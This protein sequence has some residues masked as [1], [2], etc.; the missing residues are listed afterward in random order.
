MKYSIIIPHHNV[1]GLLKRCL[2]S[3]PQR[4]DLEVIVVDDKSDD[5][6]ITE[7][8]SICDSRQNTQLLLLSENRGG[9]GARNEGLK[10]AQGDFLLF[11]DAD[12]FFNYCINDILDEYKNTTNDLVFF[13]ANCVDSETYCIDSRTQHLNAY[14]DQWMSN[15]KES[16]INLR[17]MFGEPWCKLIRKS[18]VISHDIKFDT[19]RRNN[20][21]TFSYLVGYFS[22]NISVDQR[23]LYCYTTGRNSVSKQSSVSDYFTMIDVF[24][25]SQLFF[26]S[27]GI[28]LTETR[29]YLALYHLIRELKIDNFLE[30][31]EKL[32]EQGYKRNRV[33]D[34]FA[35]AVAKNSILSSLWC[36]WYVPSFYGRILCFRYLL[37]MALPKFIKEKIFRMSNNEIKRW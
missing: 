37:T 6:I 19:T 2:A 10:H 31:V 14:I 26:D 34:S 33:Y 25:R 1:P 36:S 13:R 9:G 27:K 12:D 35:R 5:S 11:A 17:Y 16:E 28:K 23:C 32:V 29:Q 20:D 8:H 21:T 15:R 30:G 3:I 18:V 22:K 24:G 7:L 4:A